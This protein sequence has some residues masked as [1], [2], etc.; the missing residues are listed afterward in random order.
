MSLTAFRSLSLG[1]LVK[2]LL[3]RYLITGKPRPM[4]RV[5]RSIAL[6]PEL[7]VEDVVTDGP[8]LTP[9][10]DKS[11]FSAIHMASQGYW[12]ISDDA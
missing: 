2:R 9:V 1:N 3:A 8:A 7:K 12:Q 4:G 6:G 5:R 11:G 10:Q